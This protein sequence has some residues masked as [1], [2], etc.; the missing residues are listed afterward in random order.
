MRSKVGTLGTNL[1][2]IE[3]D[4]GSLSSTATSYFLAE[5]M[6]FPRYSS[7]LFVINYSLS[8]GKYGYG[9]DDV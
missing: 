1:F 7:C 8:A 2:G 9:K 5:Q 4:T 3:V 6:T